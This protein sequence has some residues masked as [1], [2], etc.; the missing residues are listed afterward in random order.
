[1]L[2][3]QFVNTFVL[4]LI[5]SACVFFT[6]SCPL[7][8][9]P[10]SNP[11]PYKRFKLTERKLDL[12]N[13]ERFDFDIDIITHEK[14][15]LLVA[16]QKTQKSNKQYLGRFFRISEDGG[17]TFG[18][19]YPYPKILDGDIEEYRYY[20]KFFDGG[21]ATLIFNLNRNK[22]GFTDNM[23]YSRTDESFENWSEPA[24]VNDVIG[25][26][27]VRCNLIHLG[28]D[29]VLCWWTDF[30]SGTER[31]YFSSSNDGGK[32]WSIN[33]EIES[34]FRNAS[35]GIPTIGFGKNGR[36]HA[37]WVDKRDEK[38]LLNIRHS[39]S[40]DNGKN[41]SKSKIINDD[42]LPVLAIKSNFYTSKWNNHSI[43]C[44]FSG[45][46]G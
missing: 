46:W 33:T 40:D 28:I 38:T 41:W 6:V 26:I 30:R 43:F 8:V 10:N 14:K 34:D 13:W 2:S 7:K 42:E 18:K 27:L 44:R 20:F 22:D 17:E 25:K 21:I 36:I 3:R 39:Y 37:V 15:R 11:L 16:Y 19:E 32:T 24:R 5:I 12:G 23:F 1:M 35:Q 45:K 4:L 9:S 31:A 29:D